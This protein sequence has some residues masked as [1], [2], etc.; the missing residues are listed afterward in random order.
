MEIGYALLDT[1]AASVHLLSFFTF[2]PLQTMDSQ[3]VPIL[4]LYNMFFRF[5][6]PD[7]AELGK[8]GGISHRG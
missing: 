3:Q 7:P 2:P 5:V 6:A 8:V 1:G 4:G